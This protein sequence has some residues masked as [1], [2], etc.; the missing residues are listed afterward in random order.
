MEG[1]LSH[2]SSEWLKL[3]RKCEIKVLSDEEGK[4]E[5][6]EDNGLGVDLIL[7]GPIW[8]YEQIRG[9]EKTYYS[10]LLFGRRKETVLSPV[11]LTLPLYYFD[12]LISA[13]WLQ[14]FFKDMIG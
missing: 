7:R 12:I 6:Q 9:D 5:F 8:N 3:E 10:E 1:V 11:C 4:E 14:I 2:I 13:H